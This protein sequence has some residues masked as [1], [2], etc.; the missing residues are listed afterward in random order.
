MHP[1]GMLFCVTFIWHLCRMNNINKV[2][3]SDL[4]VR[5][6]SFKMTSGLKGIFK[7]T[8]TV[9]NSNVKLSSVLASRQ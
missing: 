1:T 7:V 3:N 6:H 9:L 8:D 2:L 5:C 4:T